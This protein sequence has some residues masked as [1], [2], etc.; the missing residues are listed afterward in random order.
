MYPQ[1]ELK[2]RMTQGGVF[3]QKKV[4]Q[5]FCKWTSHYYLSGSKSFLILREILNILLTDSATMNQ[6]VNKKIIAVTKLHLQCI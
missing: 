4:V 6:P 5:C 1:Y 2:S 3:T